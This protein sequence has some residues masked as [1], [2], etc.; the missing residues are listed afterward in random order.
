MEREDKIIQLIQEL[1]G[2]VNN[3]QEGQEKLT[4]TVTNMRLHLENVTD[5]NI[6]LIMEQYVPNTEKLDIATKK[7]EKIEFEVDTIKKVVISHSNEINELIKL[8]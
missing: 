2:K 3:I 6:Q 7:I 8:N 4:E 5:K 1:S